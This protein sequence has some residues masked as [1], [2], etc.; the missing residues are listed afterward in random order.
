MPTHTYLGNFPSDHDSDWSDDLQGVTHDDEH[1]YF[2]QRTKIYKFH[3]STDLRESAGAAVAIAKMPDDLD[4][5]G[6]DHFGD[7]SY[8]EK[9]GQGYLFVPVE[10]GDSLLIPGEN[11]CSQLPFLAVFRDDLTYVGSSMLPRQRKSLETGRAGWCAVNPKDEM[12]YTSSN[13]IKSDKP[14]FRY[15]IN[16]DALQNADVV[17]TPFDD[18]VLRENNAS[19]DPIHIPKYVQGGTF[20]EEGWLYIANG[21]N[22]DDKDGGIRV[23][24]PDGI[25]LDRSSITDEPFKYEF[26]SGALKFEEPEGLTFWDLDLLGQTMPIPGIEGQL[27]AILLDNNASTDEIFFKHYR[28]DPFG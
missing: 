26:H 1:W 19:L 9:D 16:F 23:F 17:L 22:S 13:E 18:F 12:L 20:S 2:T 4:S 6:C 24:D 14:V 3:V 27:H 25:L 11:C 5:L 8:Y 15:V 7:L 28:L 10:G 21:G